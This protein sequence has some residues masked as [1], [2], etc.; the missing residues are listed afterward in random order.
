MML[1]IPEEK[2]HRKILVHRKYFARHDMCNLM[3]VVY[4]QNN[5]HLL[6]IQRQNRIDMFEDCNMLPLIYNSI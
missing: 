3:E 1:A 4:N 5:R 6:N 2:C